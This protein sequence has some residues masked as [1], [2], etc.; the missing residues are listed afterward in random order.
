VPNADT[1]TR[2]SVVC[3][4][5][6]GPGPASHWAM[7]PVALLLRLLVRCYQH[8]LGTVLPNTC[9]YQPTCS[10]YALEALSEYGAFRGAWLAL[11]RILRCH[12]FARGGY[13]PVPP[14]V[15]AAGQRE[16]VVETRRNER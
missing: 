7:A 11:M 8:T 13:D 6:R 4:D 9:R 10:H 1:R 3:A 16:C 15:R 5:S 12:P 14:R 2:T